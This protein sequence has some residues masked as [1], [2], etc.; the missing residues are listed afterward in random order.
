MVGEKP[1]TGWLKIPGTGGDFGMAPLD[2]IKL[3][4]KL[5][6]IKNPRERDRILHL[7]A[8]QDMP[9]NERLQ[10]EL[11]RRT[12]TQAGPFPA[13]PSERKPAPD[14]EPPE[15]PVRGMG[16][17]IGAVMPLFFL[18]VGAILVLSALAGIGKG[19]GP[20]DSLSELPMAIMFIIFGLAGLYKLRKAKKK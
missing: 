2:R 12:P 20:K 6:T 16:F 11:P 15:T 10:P 18:L 14:A 9:E 1:G 13:P 4:R 3:I 7:L 17:L 19:K 8:G 5:K